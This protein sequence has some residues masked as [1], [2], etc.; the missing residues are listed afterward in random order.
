[1]I[2]SIVQSSQIFLGS[3][4][5]LTTERNK[6]LRRKC[7]NL[8]QMCEQLTGTKYGRLQGTPLLA[9]TLRFGTALQ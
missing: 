3:T 4:K 9:Y 5:H 7:S 6:S 2:C 8:R 1:M